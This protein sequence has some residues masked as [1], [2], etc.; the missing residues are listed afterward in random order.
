MAIPQTV[1]LTAP[2]TQIVVKTERTATLEFKAT[3]RKGKPLEGIWVGMYPSVFRLWGMYGWMKVSSETPYREIPHLP[4]LV[5]S[6][7]TDQ[8]GRL[9]LRNIPAEE[10]GLDIDSP[11]YQVPLQ[12]P[13]GWRDR[14]VRTTFAPGE[15]NRLAITM[16]PKGTD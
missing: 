1:S 13:K 7:K 14:Y 12:E 10:H 9:V 6:G 11:R 16:E 4:D 5:F 8:D 2:V 3:D 15:T